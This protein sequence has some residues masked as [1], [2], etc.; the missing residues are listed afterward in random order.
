[1]DE[2]PDFYS[3]DSPPFVAHFRAQAKDNRRQI[4][5]WY[6]TPIRQIEQL[7]D[8]HYAFACWHVSTFDTV[9]PDPDPTEKLL[10]SA[11]HKNQI[12]LFAL[13][14]MTQA[15]LFG[16]ARPL[17]RQ[18]FEAQV[19]AKFAALSPNSI[20]ARKWANGEYVPIGRLVF[21]HIEQPAMEPAVAFWG[22]LHRY[23]HASPSS[24]QVSLYAKHNQ[25]EIGLDLIF[26]TLL[27]FNQTHLLT[28]HA[29][30]ATSR[31]YASRYAPSQTISNLRKEMRQ[32]LG[33][34]HRHFSS[35]GKALV[36]S[37]RA[38]W[39]IGR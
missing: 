37:Y 16:P 34:M 22:V 18:V 31:R 11:V 13:L 6:N 32:L 28:Q 10:F 30:S 24:Q 25:D 7:L 19:I 26:I 35:E 17:L 8:L 36:R 9:R 23:V 5:I 39:I 1:L 2:E 29:F 14:E 20:V 4:R 38:P 12:A 33:A 21:P 15:G 3:V 27:L